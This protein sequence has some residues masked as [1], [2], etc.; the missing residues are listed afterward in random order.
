[1]PLLSA[2]ARWVFIS[3]SDEVQYLSD[4]AF[5][6]S[7]LLHRGFPSSNISLF[8]DSLPPLNAAALYQFPAGLRPLSTSAFARTMANIQNAEELVIVVTGHGRGDNGAIDTAPP[9]NPTLLLQAI[10][11]I[12]NLKNAVVVMGQ[13]FTGAFNYVDAEPARGSGL[14]R[15]C[16]MG[17][18]ELS[19]SVSA[20]IDIAVLPPPQNAFVNPTAWRANLFLIGFFSWVTNPVDIDGDTRFTVMDAYKSAGIQASQ[21][22][23]QIKAAAMVEMFKNMSIITADPTTPTQTSMRDQLLKALNVMFTDQIPWILHSNFARE[24]IF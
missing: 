21:I 12:P 2:T 1:M 7:A 14:A 24:L 9:I 3:G 18:T 5:G 6:V 22:L 23:V 11:S 17:A 19:Y 8:I 20:G 15:V 16:L 4:I 13:C 10:R